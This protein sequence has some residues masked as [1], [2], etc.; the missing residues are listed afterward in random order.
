M[1][2]FRYHAELGV[3]QVDVV[4]AWTVEEARRYGRE[5]GQQFQHARDRSGCLRLLLN[6]LQSDLMTQDVI[7]SLMRSGTQNGQPDDIIAIVA[8]SPALDLQL[9]RMFSE[10]DAAM[11]GSVEQ[12]LSWL[13]GEGRE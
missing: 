2:E 1:F 8:G 10:R 12:A 3:M 7:L 6:L 4:G 11:F 5:A 13:H 9:R